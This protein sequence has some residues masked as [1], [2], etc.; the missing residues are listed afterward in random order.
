MNEWIVPSVFGILISIIAYFLKTNKSQSDK[1]AEEHEMNIKQ[2]N[3]DLQEYK[4]DVAD[5]F[6]LKDDFIRATA[7]TDRKLDKIY[8][9]IIKLSTRGKEVGHE[10]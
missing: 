1:R 8:D 9:E 7:Q 5:R 4:L 2:L 6:V 10:R 3:H